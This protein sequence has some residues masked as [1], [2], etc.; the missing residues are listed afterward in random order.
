MRHTLTLEPD[1]DAAL[2]EACR[3]TG[4]PFKEVVNTIPRQGL[5]VR[6]SARSAPPLN[7]EPFE[8]GLKEG[9]SLISIS[10]MESLIEEEHLR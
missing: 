7:F 9:L 2:A 8:M 1:V 5:T 4:K 6:E 3:A 10:T